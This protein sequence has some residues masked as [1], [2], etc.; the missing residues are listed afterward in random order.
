M[1]ELGVFV[2]VL[3]AVCSG[4]GILAFNR[5]E[6]FEKITKS[7]VVVCFSIMFIFCSLHSSNKYESP[8]QN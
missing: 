3:I 5:Y 2:T 4:V 7:I 8:K 6:A 1:G